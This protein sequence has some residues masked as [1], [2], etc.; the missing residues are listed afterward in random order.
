MKA[1]CARS[2][3]LTFTPSGMN[4]GNMTLAMNRTA[5]SGTPRISSTYSTHSSFTA[6]SPVD[7]RPSATSTASGNAKRQAE[8][9][10]DQSQRQAA[11]EILGHQRQPEHAAEH[12]HAD[13]GQRADQISASSLRQNRRM[14]ET[15][16]RP[17]NSSTTIAGRHCSSY[18]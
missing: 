5:I 16:Y 8:R 11:P 2:S 17:M 12:Q 13:D 14:A 10:Q 4:S 6:G 1:I 3:L 18:G 7:R 15:T 9:R